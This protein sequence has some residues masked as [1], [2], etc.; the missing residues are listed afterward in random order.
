MTNTL[1]NSFPTVVDILGDF[2]VSRKNERVQ[3]AIVSIFVRTNHNKVVPWLAK[4]TKGEFDTD[5]RTKAAD[6]LLGFRSAE[7]I[8]PL[9]WL[10]IHDEDL[11]LR[12]NIANK[13]GK[14][15]DVKWQEK[16]NL[17]LRE[18][19]KDQ[20]LFRENI[21]VD[22]LHI[23]I[24]P[25]RQ[26]MSGNRFILTDF[27]IQCCE[28]LNGEAL[29][30]VASLIIKSTGNNKKA[31]GERLNAVS[32]LSDEVLRKLRIEIGGETALAPILQENLKKYFQDPIDCLNRKTI[33]MWRMTVHDARLGFMTRMVLSV[34][35]F[36][37]GIILLCASG[38]RVIFG[39]LEVQQLWGPGV[40]F[41]TGLGMMLLIVYSG[42]LKEIRK[43]VSDL[44]IA[45]AAFIAYVHRILEISHTFT[46]LY[47]KEQVSYDEMTKSSELIGLS[48]KETI[49]SLQ[50]PSDHSSE[51][52]IKRVIE[53]LNNQ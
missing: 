49:E 5:L 22:L 15:K 20:T 7:A 44:G 38:Y 35:V 11:N 27:L 30:I 47:L 23:V 48:M 16:V 13:L 2:L 9:I 19:E 21:E 14:Y 40:S 1:S 42:P 34:V 39:D 29:E 26:L 45:N 33:S 4:V 3:N 10:V 31:V 6:R 51:D 52:L 41:I 36:A 32:G 28:K 24:Q 25:P 12:Q 17:V 50:T 53:R 46:F 8:Q 37:F 18:L 43:S